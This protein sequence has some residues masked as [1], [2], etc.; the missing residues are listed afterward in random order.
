MAFLEINETAGTIREVST[1]KKKNSNR[2]IGMEFEA[3]V[4]EERLMGFQTTTPR[5]TVAII[6]PGGRPVV[7]HKDFF[8]LF[9]GISISADEVLCWQA[10]KAWL[11]NKRKAEVIRAEIR[12]FIP[13]CPS[14]FTF[15]IFYEDKEGKVAIE[16]IKHEAKFKGD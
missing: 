6:Y 14:N 4:L 1:R 11:S 9:D 10:K 13:K 8:G 2:K 12:A 5:Q 3:R 7:L 15:A 16:W